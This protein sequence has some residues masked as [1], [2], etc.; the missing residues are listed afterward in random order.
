MQLGEGGAT[1]A[2]RLTD[3]GASA[4]VVNLGILYIQI[5][6]QICSI[7]YMRAHEARPPEAGSDRWLSKRSCS[8]IHRCALSP[9]GARRE[10]QP[11]TLSPAPELP[12]VAASPASSAHPASAAL[13]PRGMHSQGIE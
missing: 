12:I 6:I 9:G 1:S 5:Y 13:G 4:K 2:Q 8:A 10:T 11:G 7:L 3:R